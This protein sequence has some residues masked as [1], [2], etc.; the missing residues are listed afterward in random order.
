MLVVAL[1]AFTLFRFVG[2]PIASMVGQDTTNEQRVLLREQLGLNDSIP[3]QFG[4]FVL[5]V[6]QGD[7]GIS[8]RHRIPVIDLITDRLP[9]TLEL[10]FISAISGDCAWYTTWGL[11]RDKPQRMVITSLHVAL[12]NRRFS[13]HISDR[14]F[15]D[16]MV[17][18]EPEMAACFRAG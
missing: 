12:T 2:D 3:I 14:P 13:S 7:F 11:Y 17:W 5:N 8:Y 10:S 16:F 4:R 1:I 15:I 6:V 9:A 18:R